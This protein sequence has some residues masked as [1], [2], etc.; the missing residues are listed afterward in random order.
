MSRKPAPAQ[1][2]PHRMRRLLWTPLAQ[3]PGAGGAAGT[4]AGTAVPAVLHIAVRIGE[5]L[6]AGGQG[7]EDVEAVMLGVTHAYRLPDCEP[8]VTFTMISVSW[9]AGPDAVPILVDRTVRHRE[10]D[11][12]RLT[13]VYRL[14][15]DILNERATPAQARARL[16]V[17]SVLPPLYPAAVIAAATG[18][19][20]ASASVLV[21]GRSDA[22]A[23]VTFL[24]AFAAAVVGDRLAAVLAAW[25]SPPFYRSAA[26]AVP[27]AA[28]GVVMALAGVGLGGSAVVTGSLFALFPGKTLVGA[29]E[30]GLTGFYLTAAARLVEVLYL[31]TG[32]ITGVLAVLPLGVRLGAV[33]PPVGGL[34]GGHQNVVLHIAAAMVLAVCLAAVLQTPAGILPYTAV[35]G[36][37]AW[38]VFHLL[39]SP[40]GLN[41]IFATGTGACAGGLFGQL[42][43]RSRHLYSLPYVTGALGPLLPGSLLYTGVLALVEGRGA[44]GLANL[45][46]AAATALALAVGVNIGSGLPR[47][48]QLGTSRLPELRSR[49]RRR[50]RGST[51]DAGLQEP[52]PSSV[53]DVER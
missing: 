28:A 31:V 19:I 30:D 5:L 44:D 40:L 7:A 25:R 29:V 4:A 13:G 17:I 50:R 16:D 35:G 10:S 46:R 51:D 41:P 15:D 47:L 22:R 2:I 23:A 1:W 12:R 45:S 52:G 32:I 37:I 36:G 18:G 49:P 34:G 42:A 39:S 14:V 38:A 48:A 8:Q 24:V 11:Y 20:A 43:A 3:R 6:L 27:A 53:S 9:Q 26:A 21:S 33:F